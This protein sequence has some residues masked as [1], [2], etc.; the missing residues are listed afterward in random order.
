MESSVIKKKD[1]DNMDP[2]MTKFYLM[3][4]HIHMYQGSQASE[5][6]QGLACQIN[7]CHLHFQRRYLQMSVIDDSFHNV[8]PEI[9]NYYTGLQYM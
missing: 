3:R 2:A 6:L 9:I 4:S 7:T 5:N 8:L 1:F